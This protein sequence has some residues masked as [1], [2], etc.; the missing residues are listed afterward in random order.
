MVQFVP[1]SVRVALERSEVVMYSDVGQNLAQARVDEARMRYAEPA[2]HVAVTMRWIVSSAVSIVP[3][4]LLAS[5]FG[6][7]HPWVAV[8]AL[9]TATAIVGTVGW[10]YVKACVNKMNVE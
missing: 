6:N 4:V 8:A 3:M 5:V 2:R 7:L 9:G 1:A 10:P